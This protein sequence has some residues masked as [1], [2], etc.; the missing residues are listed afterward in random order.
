LGVRWT[1]AV[2]AALRRRLVD[3]GRMVA[4]APAVVDVLAARSDIDT[5]RLG[6]LG[7]SLGGYY[8][9]RSAAADHRF[10]VCVV[11][12][13]LY[14]LSFYERMHE[15]TQQGFAYVSGGGT[16]SEAAGRLANLVNLDDV[17]SELR[18]P[19]YVQHGARRLAGIRPPPIAQPALPD[20]VLCPGACAPPSRGPESP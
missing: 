5:A 15:L 1:P 20:P 14:D 9:V 4:D 11:W 13:G 19:L 2:I 16:P 6:V 7:R 8:A 10:R 18:A 17:I 3:M 12:G